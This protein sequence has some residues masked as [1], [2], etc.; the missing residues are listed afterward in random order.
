VIEMLEVV[1]PLSD[2]TAHGGN[3]EDAFDL[4]IPSLPGYGFSDEPK[5]V[6]R[7]VGRIAQA[8]AELMSRRHSSHCDERV[9]HSCA[10]ARCIADASS[11]NGVIKRLQA[12]S[13]QVTA[14][15]NPL[16]GLAADSA[17]IAGVFDET[18]GPAD[19]IREAVG[20]VA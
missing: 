17:Y 20:A 6:G 5:E 11:W 3:A 13:V 16:R 9:T 14:P 10:C 8:W 18:P 4:V 1:G 2:P 12:R 15:A 7:D 19:V